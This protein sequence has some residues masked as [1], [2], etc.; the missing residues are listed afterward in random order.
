MAVVAAAVGLS[1]PV[2]VLKQMEETRRRK[3]SEQLVDALMILSSSLKAGLSIVQAFEVIVE[4]MP[5]P[6]SQ[7]FSLVGRQLKMGVGLEE[8]LNKMKKRMRS[9]DL[10]LIVSAMMVARET[11]GNLPD[12]F[13][14]ITSTIKERNKLISKVNALCV[15]GKLQGII[16]SFI[17]IGFAAFVYQTNPEFFSIF[18]TDRLGRMLIGY[19][20]VSEILGIFFIRKLSRIE[21]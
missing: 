10:D 13:A 18:L 4:E 14:Q 7:E 12:T 6:I 17:P 19:A 9:E 1:I 21:I 3:F 2:L 8:T 11:G 15:Q 20:V 16:M 5:P